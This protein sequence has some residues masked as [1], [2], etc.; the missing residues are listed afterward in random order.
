[1]SLIERS[2]SKKLILDSSSCDN[3]SSEDGCG[4]NERA[5]DVMSM[6]QA[7]TETT[8]E[9]CMLLN[10]LDVKNVLLTHDQIAERSEQE[11]MERQKANEAAMMEQQSDSSQDPENA[12]G[13]DTLKMLDNSNKSSYDSLDGNTRPC[14]YEQLNNESSFEKSDVNSTPENDFTAVLTEEGKYLL[15]KAAHYSVENL[16]LVNIEKTETPLGATIRNLDGSIM[17]GRIVNGGAAE[18]SG[19]LHED[20]EILEIN[21]VPVRGKTIN[22]ICEMLFNI[23]GIVSF[24]IIP[25]MDYEPG[26]LHGTMV[27]D[28][29]VKIDESS[30]DNILHIRALYNYV[31][32]ED[33]YV[34]CKELGLGFNKGDIL[35]VISKED[36]D[37]WQA[38]RDEDKEQA[39]A[40]LIPSQSFQER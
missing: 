34:P 6:S 20:D 29:D 1:M 8:D 37:W 35:H 22:D 18:R 39:L 12:C 23:Q 19:L 30:V 4:F 17:I 16:K 21:S 27:G 15:Q 32:M 40:G 3:L 33:I 2:S 38:Y 7:T 36:D 25:N 14:S 26:K 5:I 11:V 10:K 9:L 24:L 28:G 13:D 31:P